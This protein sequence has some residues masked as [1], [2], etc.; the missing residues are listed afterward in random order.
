MYRRLITKADRAAARWIPPNSTAIP[1]PRGIDAA[2]VYTTDK[3]VNTPLKGLQMHYSAVAYRGTAAHAEWNY[4]YRTPEQRETKIKE[5]FDSVESHLKYRTERNA[6]RK[7][8]T[9][10]LSQ[11]PKA[12]VIHLST[13][14]TARELR[15]TLKAA[16]PKTQFTVRS[17]VYSMGSSIDVRWT[18]GPT[19]AQVDAIM[20]CFE[21]CGFDGMQDLKT[22]RAPCLWRGHRVSW[23][24]DYVHGSRSESFETLKAAALTIAEECDLPLL[25]IVQDGEYSHVKPG[26]GLAVPWRTYKKDDGTLGFA[27]DSQRNESYDQL[28]YQYARSLS[29]EESQPVILPRRIPKPENQPAAPR[30]AHPDVEAAQAA[31]DAQRATQ[32]GGHDYEELRAKV[33]AYQRADPRNRLV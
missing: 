19:H 9:S 30:P 14:A 5:F 12:E 16:F 1:H 21:N 3:E 27:H 26:F 24:A 17:S 11:P 25:E 8:E 28:I 32:P 31:L 4:Y 10:P 6:Q 2:V 22:Y 15:E 20:D 7:A 29:M 23:G 33:E 18:D 13:A